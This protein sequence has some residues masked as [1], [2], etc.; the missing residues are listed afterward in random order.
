MEWLYWLYSEH[1]IAYGLVMVIGGLGAVFMIT[2]LALVL[3][4]HG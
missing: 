3:L 1:P 2:G 4:G